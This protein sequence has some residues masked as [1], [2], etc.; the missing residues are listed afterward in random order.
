[1]T[2]ESPF[3]WMQYYQMLNAKAQP[4]HDAYE[5]IYD[6]S[7][8]MPDKRFDFQYLPKFQEESP[9]RG[10]RFVETSFGVQDVAPNAVPW[11]DLDMGTKLNDLWAVGIAKRG[12]SS[13]GD[14]WAPEDI[15]AVQRIVGNS[16]SITDEHVRRFSQYLLWR[17]DPHFMSLHPGRD[18]YTPGSGQ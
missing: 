15:A 1:M 4:P 8:P 12:G 18:A 17:R 14:S 16:K 9:P 10:R 5:P 13:E 6:K 3:D 7:W 11:V 2:S